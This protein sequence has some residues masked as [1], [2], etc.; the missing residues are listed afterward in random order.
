MSADFI[1]AE[2]A[3]ALR[4][5]SANEAGADMIPSLVRNNYSMGVERRDGR[6]VAI[7]SMPDGRQ[8]TVDQF[9]IEA[10]NKWPVLFIGTR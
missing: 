5:R 10:V 2:L 7:V 6:K 4:E 8:L 9:A 3:R 1:A